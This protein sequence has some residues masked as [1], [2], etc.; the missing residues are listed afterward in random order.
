MRFR[1]QLQEGWSTLFI[2]W[3]MLLV[4]STAIMQTDLI[5]GLHII[6]IAAS[7]AMFLGLA[8]AKSQFRARTAHLYALIVG[9][10]VLFYLVGTILP[11]DLVWRERV[12]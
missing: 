10:F 3:A 11:G 4:A 7:V 6:P 9:L 8:L 5:D 2:L 12:F 1:P